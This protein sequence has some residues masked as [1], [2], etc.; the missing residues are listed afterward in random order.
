MTTDANDRDPRPSRTWGWSPW[1]AIGAGCLVVLLVRQLGVRR[2]VQQCLAVGEV[3]PAILALTFLKYPLQTTGWR[4]ALPPGQRPPW[5]LSLR[6]TLA[7]EA[8]GYVT[9]AGAIA[10]EPFRAALL[11]SY[12]PLPTGIVAGAVERSLYA[13][14]GTLVVA[15]ALT[16]S[17]T[18]FG[19]NAWIP[20]VVA[21]ILLLLPVVLVLLGWPP[22]RHGSTFTPTGWRG[23][24][25]RLWS[26]RRDALIPIGLLCLAQHAV[27]IGE[28]YLVLSALGANPTVATV[29]MFEGITKT[30]NSVGAVVPG[31]LGI[32][33][34][35]SAAMAG[36]LG[37]GASFGVSLVLMRRVRALFWS[38]LGLVL[39]TPDLWRTIRSARDGAS[40]AVDPA[41]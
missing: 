8:I 40:A 18:R 21:G 11:K 23:V 27:M 38:T 24:L 19:L 3:L 20:A 7:G 16:I 13:I 17:A 6:A 4:L 37:I 33:E 28:G 12:L 32:A 34:G 2:I 29:L 25:H 5:W 22:P 15:V 1:L 10:A 41:R 14:T 35:S 26:E 31:R 30:A 39:A 36:A 9:L